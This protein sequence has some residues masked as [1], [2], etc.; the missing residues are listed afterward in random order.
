MPLPPPSA[1]ASRLGAL[2]SFTATALPRHRE[3]VTSHAIV[4][5]EGSAARAGAGAGAGSERRRRPPHSSQAGAG[6]R[7]GDAGQDDSLAD[8][9]AD[10]LAA[11]ALLSASSPPHAHRVP[12]TQPRKDGRASGHEQALTAASAQS[13]STT[14]TRPAPAGARAAADTARPGS[15]ATGKRKQPAATAASEA[16]AN[17]APAIKRRRPG[18]AP[19]A[20]SD[21]TNR[22]VVRQRV[23]AEFVFFFCFL[24]WFCPRFNDILMFVPCLSFFFFWL[25]PEWWLQAARV[26]PAV[27]SRGCARLHLVR[28]AVAR[29]EHGLLRGG[30]AHADARG[31]CR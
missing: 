21:G 28:G 11:A 7:A 30:L 12:H 19:A 2:T 27:A 17:P 14:R 3:A 13:M 22:R 20:V 23:R 25:L 9:D 5:D 4:H 10:Y 15:A 18:A 16:S 29:H 1:L 24:L 26:A 8:A 31:R 6:H